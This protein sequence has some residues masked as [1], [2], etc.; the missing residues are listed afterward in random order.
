MSDFELSVYDR[1]ME[2]IDMICYEPAGRA[3]L[4]S[5]A[6]RGVENPAR[7]YKYLFQYMPTGI[8]ESGERAWL[9]A[10]AI[11]ASQSEDKRRLAIPPSG[12]RRNIGACL[13]G[14]VVDGILEEGPTERRL[15]TLTR[16]SE[17]GLHRQL[18]STIRYLRAKS[19]EVDWGQLLA[20][21][22]SWHRQRGTTARTWSRTFYQILNRTT[23]A[24]T[25]IEEQR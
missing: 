2:H 11:Y 17:A 15:I 25:D 10:A 13:G 23:L 16:Q 14:A 1:Y 4:R 24:A 12:R 9:L 6:G 18:P 7:M 5:G 21:L 22:A 19:V 3:A 8:S 20:D